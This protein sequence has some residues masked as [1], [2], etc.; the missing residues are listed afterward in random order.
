M[1]SALFLG[2]IPFVAFPQQGARLP[3][4]DHMYLV[5]SVAKGET[6]VVVNGRSV[7]VYR[8]G[9]WATLV[10]VAEGSNSVSV[11]SQSG[12]AADVWFHI[13]KKP[14]AAPSAG[15]QPERKWEKLPYAKDEAKDPPTNRVPREIT[16]VVDP[17]HGGSDTGARSPHGF[18]EK[19]ANLLTALCVRD[20][21]VSRGYNV[22]LT[23][24]DDSF[25]AL[26]DR[27][28]VAHALNADAFV[29]IHH[30]APPYD[31]DPN[32]LRYHA[33]YSWNAIGERLA[34]AVSARMG[35]ALGGTLKS[36]GAIHANYAVT[37]NPEIPSCLVEVDFVTSPAGE[38]A[39]WDPKRRA[40]VAR[41]IA[42]G[43][44]DWCRGAP[45]P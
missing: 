40:R 35:E 3:A 39:I 45:V 4:I 10:D 13:A 30:N 44:A 23:R 2:A 31:K 18:C 41:A 11:V 6:N 24:E 37:R 19:D 16:I 14:A 29:S 22:A 17:G 32:L 28:K 21:L 7:P 12:E 15:P 25:P 38:E 43:I 42:D 33:V 27:P 1:L 9:A 34:K 26:Y 8:T 5:G 20:E 36:N